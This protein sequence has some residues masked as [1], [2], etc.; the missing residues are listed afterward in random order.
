MGVVAEVSGEG[1]LLELVL[2][3]PKGN[4]LSRAVMQ[5]L[6]GALA[7]H[8]GARRLRLVAIRGAGKHFS[9]GA[10]VEEHRRELA[11]AMLSTFHG[12]IRR[13]G[14]YP[15]P[16][17]A[18]VDGKCLGG[19]FELALACHLVVATEAAAFACPEIKLGVLPP[20]LAA[21]GAARLG[22]ATTERMLLTG[23]ELDA[24][25]AHALGF[26][27]E[28]IPAGAELGPWVREYYARSFAKLSAYALRQGVAATRRSLAPL[29]DRGIAEAEAQYLAHVL[30]SHDGNEG[31]E[32][33]IEKRAPVWKDE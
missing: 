24:R 9:F 16:I 28:L 27:S 32:A 3:V 8:E 14:A 30:P 25:A 15:V 21:I 4:V 2:D 23:S 29:L 1:G 10:S 11:P 5:E 20:V 17:V 22:G 19:A 26:V 33:F 12:L 6:D 31:I 18:V 7:A 13:V